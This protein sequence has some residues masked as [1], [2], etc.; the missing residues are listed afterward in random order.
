MLCWDNIIAHCIL[1]AWSSTGLGVLKQIQTCA[2]SKE[3]IFKEGAQWFGHIT[4]YASFFLQNFNLLEISASVL[5]FTSVWCCWSQGFHIR[6]VFCKQTKKR[7]ARI[8][9]WLLTSVY[10]IS[11]TI[12]SASL[13]YELCPLKPLISTKL[14]P[15]KLVGGALRS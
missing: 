8:L 3:Q 6:E 7:S 15:T 5:C 2:K 11:W 4:I 14:S 9:V 10:R 1:K 13:L 12:E